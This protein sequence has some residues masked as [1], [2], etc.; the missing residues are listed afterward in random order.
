[1]TMVKVSHIAGEQHK[2]YIWNADIFFFYPCFICGYLWLH[3]T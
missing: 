3:N 1:M 2:D